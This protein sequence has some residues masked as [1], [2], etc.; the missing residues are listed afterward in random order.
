M[1]KKI[2]ETLVILSIIVFG[3]TACGKKSVNEL[4]G[5]W[6]PYSENGAD[7]DGEYFEI[8][9]PKE[10]GDMYGQ[11]DYYDSTWEILYSGEWSIDEEEHLLKL[12]I[13]D[14]WGISDKAEFKYELDDDDVLHLIDPEDESNEEVYKK[15]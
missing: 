7:L 8:Y 12:E 2:I 5:V 14:M 13:Y 3:V 1:R 4:V 9:E 10:K 6:Y 15:I 11:L